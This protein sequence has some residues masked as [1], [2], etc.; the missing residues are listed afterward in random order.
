MASRVTK[1]KAR[2]EGHKLV[3]GT[4]NSPW[5]WEVDLFLVSADSYSELIIAIDS[6]TEKDLNWYRESA[7]PEKI[8]GKWIAHLCGKRKGKGKARDDSDE[9]LDKFDY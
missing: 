7:E 1:K 3:G 8:G 9:N 5:E 6:I 4:R 2:V